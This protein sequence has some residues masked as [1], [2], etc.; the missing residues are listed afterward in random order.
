MEARY[1]SNAVY[2]LHNSHP[3]C[4]R[5]WDE[6]KHDV[7]VTA[8][9][10]PLS[11]LPGVDSL[12]HGQQHPRPGRLGDNRGLASH[13]PCEIS[14]ISAAQGLWSGVDRPVPS[15]DGVSGHSAAG[16]AGARMGAEAAV[17]GARV[18]SE[19]TVVGTRASSAAANAGAGMSSGA[20]AVRTRQASEATPACTGK[21]GDVTVAPARVKV[22]A[23]AAI[24]LGMHYSC[25][26]CYLCSNGEGC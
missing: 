4:F 8:N 12:L 6:E 2:L 21:W 26:N 19:A 5:V 3:G 24:R 25:H 22:Q 13:S 9:I 7:V 17:E 20:A 16:H 23:V 10:R 1:L 15:L 14:T 18:R 11:I